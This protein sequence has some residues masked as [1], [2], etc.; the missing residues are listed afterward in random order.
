MAV[1]TYD[2]DADVLYV[3]LVDEQGR[4]PSNGPRRTGR[5]STSTSTL[6]ARSWASSSSIPVHMEWSGAGQGA[7]RDRSRDPVQFRGLSCLLRGVIDV[8]SADN[9]GPGPR[10]WPG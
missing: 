1:Y 8:A 4:R 3:F 6:R 2:G 10:A 5:T 9:R 7:I